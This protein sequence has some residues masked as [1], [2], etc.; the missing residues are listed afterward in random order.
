MNKANSQNPRTFKEFKSIVRSILP[1]SRYSKGLRETEDK[2]I[3]YESEEFVITYC[4]E[5]KLWFSK[6][7]EHF[8]SNLFEALFG[9][10]E[11]YLLEKSLLK[12]V[13]DSLYTYSYSVTEDYK[14][15]TKIE[16]SPFDTVPGALVLRLCRLAGYNNYK[17]FTDSMEIDYERECR[18]D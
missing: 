15:R 3:Y 5:T 14:N 9:K 12:E 18:Q 13:I 8:G 6:S 17:E 16:R 7:T 11:G 10:V 1:A 2:F 4:K